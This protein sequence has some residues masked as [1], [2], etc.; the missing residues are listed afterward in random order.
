[1]VI[2]VA[3]LEAIDVVISVHRPMRN[4]LFTMATYISSLLTGGFDS[5]TTHPAGA[6]VKGKFS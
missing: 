4:F 6:T 5:N 2:S 3:E 1:M